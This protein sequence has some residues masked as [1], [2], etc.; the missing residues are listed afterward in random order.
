V[1]LTGEE[2]TVGAWSAGNAVTGRALLVE[3]DDELRELG[4]RVLGE[5]G[6]RVATA[7]SAEE[8]ARVFKE[9]GPFD[10]LVSDVMLPGRSGLDLVHDLHV[11]VVGRPVLLVTGYSEEVGPL[12]PPGPYLQVLRK[13]YRP[14]EMVF[15]VAVLLGGRASG[16][17]G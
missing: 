4:A 1:P 12:P 13:P 16:A 6:L 9:D 15:A 3:D 2:G 14:E 7:G 10:V 8:G 5:A 11:G 17:L